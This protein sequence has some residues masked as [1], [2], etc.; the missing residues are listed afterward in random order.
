MNTVDH[1]EVVPMA[2]HGHE[3]EH[4]HDEHESTPE[5]HGGP[6]VLDPVAASEPVADTEQDE[7]SWVTRLVTGPGAVSGG[8]AGPASQTGGTPGP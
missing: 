6:E 8:N 4:E 5:E 7:D 3:H 2:H 1:K